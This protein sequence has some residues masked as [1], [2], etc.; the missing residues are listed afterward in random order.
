MQSLSQVVP[1]ALQ[2]SLCGSNIGSQLLGMNHHV[3]SFAHREVAKK[4]DNVGRNVNQQHAAQTDVV[5]HESNH[6]TGNQPSPLY[7]RQQ[8]SVRM[9]EAILRSEFLNERGDGWPEHP[10]S[11]RDQHVH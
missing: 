8:E 10:E 3:T 7:A 1:E 5:V 2:L 6:R 11:R 4:R 9:N